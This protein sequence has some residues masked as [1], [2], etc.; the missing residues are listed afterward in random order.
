MASH[1]SLSDSKSPQVSWTLL[2]I[3]ADLNN[4]VAL[5]VFTHPL[6][7][8]SSSPCTSPLVTVPRAPMTIGI[9]V[10]FMFYSFSVLLLGLRTYLSFHFLSVS[11]RGLQERQSSLI[12]FIVINI[13]IISSSSSSLI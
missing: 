6:V 10:T 7:S 2:S 4:T 11:P 3:L 5:M 9:I 8:K 1:G 13:I 12:I